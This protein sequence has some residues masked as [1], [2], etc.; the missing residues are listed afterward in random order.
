MTDLAQDLSK[1]G[2]FI[3]VFSSRH[4][5]EDNKLR[6]PSREEY[7]GIHIRRLNNTAFG[8]KRILGRLADFFS[9]NFLLYGRLIRIKKGAYDGVICTTSP[10]LVAYIAVKA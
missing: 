1:K 10:P 8:K 3:D 6:F 7:G 5:Y 9:F 4:A 2:H